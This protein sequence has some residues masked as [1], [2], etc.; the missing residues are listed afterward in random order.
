M[1]AFCFNKIM[2]A[3]RISEQK[4]Q[5]VIQAYQQT[6]SIAFAAKQ[7]GVSEPTASAYLTTLGYRQRTQRRTAPDGMKYC[8]RCDRFLSK[9]Q[10]SARGKGKDAW[11]KSCNAKR[12]RPHA[13]KQTL[14]RLNMSRTEYEACLESQQ[15][16][17][18]I[19]G[20]EQ[21][22]TSKSGHQARLSV[23]HDHTNGHIRGLLCNRCNRGLGYFSDSPVLLSKA[24]HYL[25][26]AERKR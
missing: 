11:C 10:F 5:E 9:D 16:R 18:A 2:A 6:G 23:D 26:E 24:L 17:C 8:H 19:C 3:R 25:L 7:A 4:I 13:L 21:G 1:F 15:G 22:H 12:N 20:S 14:R